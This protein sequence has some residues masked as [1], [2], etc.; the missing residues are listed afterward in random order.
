MKVLGSKPRILE[1]WIDFFHMNH[2]P[3]IVI[4]F[5]DAVQAAHYYDIGPTYWYELLSQ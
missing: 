3:C 4:V 1:V 5:V 2:P